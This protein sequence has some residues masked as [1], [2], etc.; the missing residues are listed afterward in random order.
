MTCDVAAGVS[1]LLLQLSVNPGQPWLWHRSSCVW[2]RPR[3]ARNTELLLNQ[4][5]QR[6]HISVTSRNMLFW[7]VDFIWQLA[8]VCFCEE[9]ERERNIK[10]GPSC[11]CAAWSR[12]SWLRLNALTNSC[13]ESHSDHIWSEMLLFYSLYYLIQ[14]FIGIT[15]CLKFHNLYESGSIFVV[16]LFCFNSGTW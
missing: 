7:S 2:L 14:N 13:N 16:H 10:R 11:W 8:R 1:V 12:N 4:S 6:M 15:I 3:L 5:M 9:D